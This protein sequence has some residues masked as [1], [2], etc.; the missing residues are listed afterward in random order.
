MRR[1]HPTTL[2]A[3]SWRGISSGSPSS[4]TRRGCEGLRPWTI[5][6]ISRSDT[7]RSAPA[8]RGIVDG[9]DAA[10]RAPALEM[11]VPRTVPVATATV[12]RS[13]V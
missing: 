1:N 5:S 4:R 10:V 12:E 8:N 9:R 2:F 7:I 6:F 3:Y 11:V 13:S